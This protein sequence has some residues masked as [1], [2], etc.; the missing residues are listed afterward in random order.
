VGEIRVHDY[1][2]VSRYELQT[3]DIGRSEAELS[4]AGFGDYVWGVGF[5]E[6]VCDNLGSVRGA[7]AMMSSQPS[8]L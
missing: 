2:E 7:V 4:S 6:L 3:M 5:C 1:D 8:F